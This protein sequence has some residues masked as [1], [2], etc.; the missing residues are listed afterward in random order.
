MFVER[1]KENYDEL[2]LLASDARARRTRTNRWSTGI[3]I[4]AML[5]V[6]AYVAAMSQQVKEMRDTAKNADQIHAQVIEERDTLRAE[7]DALARYQDL[8]AQMM[9]AEASNALIAKLVDR[10]PISS[11]VGGS[12]SGGGTTILRQSE[13][14]I[15]KTNIVWM[16]EGS[17]RFPMVDGDV[18]WI[19][20]GAFWVRMRQNSDG[21]RTLHKE[22]ARPGS[23]GNSEPR[24]SV[25]LSVLPHRSAVD[26]GAYDCVEIEL[27]GDSLRP[28]FRAN[29]YVDVE[30][31]YFKSDANDMTCTSGPRE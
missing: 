10:Q 17:R 22:T 12:D 16:V 29:G 20:E 4:S 27:H 11:A 21:V 24:D 14:I 30:V 6:A 19:P 31:T 25:Q 9:P 13:P 26:K 5:G 1:R 28:V 2:L 3:V 18:L 8:Y 23:S 15:A 7:L